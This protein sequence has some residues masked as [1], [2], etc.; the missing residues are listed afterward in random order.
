MFLQAALNGARSRAEH[1]AIPLTPAELAAEAADAVAAGAHALHVH[2]RDTA[3][4]ESLA[5]ADVAGVLQAVRRRCPAVP[6]GL[7]TGA[8]II[9][10]PE[11]RRRVIA[12]WTHLPDY[13]S[14]NFDEPGAVA[15]AHDLLARGVQIEAG[16]N[17]PGA[18]ACFLEAGLA[19]RALRVLLEPAEEL[20]EEALHTLAATEQVLGAAVVS[21]P[22]LL[23]GVDATAW[24]LLHEAKR[25]RYQARIGFED[26]LALPDGTPAMGNA[27]LV[28]A[29]GQRLKAAERDAPAPP[30]RA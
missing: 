5:V 13:V 7:S 16:L 30:R 10:D 24:P 26:V 18:A 6:L 3:G 12:G 25:R 27:A 8:W 20:L 19:A 2:V 11:E 1:A 22:R 23:H 29:A 17:G 28:R 14:V 21:C 4:Q 9:P 15:L